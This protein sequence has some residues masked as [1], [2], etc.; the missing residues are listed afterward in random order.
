M[1]K[2][3]VKKEINII[4][5][6]AK[7]IISKSL[8]ISKYPPIALYIDN[9]KDLKKYEKE[10]Q[11]QLTMLLNYTA[12][13]VTPSVGLKELAYAKRCLDYTYKIVFDLA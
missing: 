8:D 9:P 12:I 7:D 5:I 4:S 2:A 10:I 6:L 3:N 1:T 13:G 11:N